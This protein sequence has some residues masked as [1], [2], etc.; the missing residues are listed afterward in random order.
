MTEP[1]HWSEG[2]QLTPS[3]YFKLG[4]LSA[5]L[6]RAVEMANSHGIDLDGLGATAAEEDLEGGSTICSPRTRCCRTGR[7]TAT[8]GS[9]AC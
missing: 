6:P 2:L 8:P 3:Q 7:R 4:T 9:T 5:A 1:I